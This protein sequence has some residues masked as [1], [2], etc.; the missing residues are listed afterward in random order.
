MPGGSFYLGGWDAGAW[1]L[2]SALTCVEG[3]GA[4]ARQRASCYTRAA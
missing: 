3:A 1:A 2:L 4:L